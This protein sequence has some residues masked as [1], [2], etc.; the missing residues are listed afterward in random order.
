MSKLRKNTT[1]M[2]PSPNP[3]LPIQCSKPSVTPP[4]TLEPHQEFQVELAWWLT[5]SNQSRN[6]ITRNFPKSQ[7][8]KPESSLISEVKD[9][10][11][12]VPDTELKKFLEEIA[13]PETDDEELIMN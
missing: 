2:I 9:M 10:L 3:T 13:D 8:G 7:T 11:K 4:T 5:K 1:K 12:D 6:G